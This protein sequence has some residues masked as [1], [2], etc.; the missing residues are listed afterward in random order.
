[1]DRQG[2]P[3]DRSELFAEL[4]GRHGDKAYH[5]AYRLAGNEQ[6]ARDLVQEAFLRAFERIDDYDPQ[7]PFDAWL[8][9]ILRNIFIDG[10]RRLSHKQTVSMDAEPEDGAPLAD[11]LSD[12]GKTALDGLATDEA[13][14]MV[15]AALAKVEPEIRTALVLCDMEGLSYEEVA[16]VMECPI[17]TVRSRLFRGRA[18]LRKLLERY[19]ETGERKHGGA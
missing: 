6:D 4:L 17:G 1:M 19:V 3:E 9:T 14:R 10:V 15:Q 5:F 11:A 8:G 18:H 16:K 13:D 2:G 7:K 12:K